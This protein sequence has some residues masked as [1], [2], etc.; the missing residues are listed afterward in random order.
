ME[1]IHTYLG[2][3]N[4]RD[5]YNC[6]IL[7]NK[8]NSVGFCKYYKNNSYDEI[9]CIEFINIRYEHRR[10][11]YATALVK[12]LQSRY[13]KED[14]KQLIQEVYEEEMA[15]TKKKGAAK[16]EPKKEAPKAP[17]APVKKAAEAPKAE[18]PSKITKSFVKTIDK[19][20][21][22]NKFAGDKG[23]AELFGKIKKILTP[24][25]GRRLEEADIDKMMGEMECDECYEEG[26]KPDFL[27]L[28]KDGN[29]KEPMK[30]AAMD[31]KTSKKLKEI[32]EKAKNI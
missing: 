18:D 6:E 14:L 27:D 7:N 11:G 31:A 4:N 30:K 21:D 16:E 28:D 20:G 24:Y 26:A 12:E 2:Y 10:R 3:N 29:K 8:K 13:T 32:I 15:E 25:V 5:E 22:K 17:K 1:F 9:V 23:D 19:H